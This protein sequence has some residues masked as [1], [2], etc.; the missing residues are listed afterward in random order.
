MRKGRNC[1]TKLFEFVRLRMST[2]AADFH[3]FAI[4]VVREDLLMD[5]VMKSKREFIPNP[6]TIECGLSSPF[7]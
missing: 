1:Y 5:T 6:R 7:A 2:T 4:T 3:R